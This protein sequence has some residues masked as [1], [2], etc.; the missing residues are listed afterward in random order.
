MRRSLVLVSL[1]ALVAAGC[2]DS[3]PE[4]EPEPDPAATLKALIAAPPVP[5][6]LL[7]PSTRARVPASDLSEGVGSFPDDAPV[8]SRG[9][10]AGWAVAWTSADRV[11]EGQQEFAAYAVALRRSGSRWLADIAGPV[12]LRPLGPEAGADAAATP[13]VAVEAKAPH[14]IEE[15][16][17]WIDGQPVD[18]KSGGPST[19][20]ISVY[21]AP[22]EPLEPGRHVAVAFARAGTTASAVAWPFTVR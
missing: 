19:R 21:G 14:A 12:Q 10:G 17:L 13:Q 20:Y 4:R 5:A 3:K 7:T 16:A 8:E 18:V 15:A 1:L 9:A 22:A 11:A 6:R 2:G